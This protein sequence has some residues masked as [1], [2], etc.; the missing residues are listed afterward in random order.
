MRKSKSPP[1][2]ATEVFLAFCS[3]K[4]AVVVMIFLT[5]SLIAATFL[6]S[7]YDTQTAQYWVY[8]A[9]YF[10]GILF[11]FGMEILAVALSRLPWKMRHTPFL[12]AHF[13]IIMLLAGSWVTDRYGLDGTIR[14][15]EG[16]TASVV[17]VNQPTLMITDDT[18][19]KPVPIR[20]T[21]PHAKFKSVSVSEYELKVDQFLSHADPVVSFVPNTD[22]S[23]ETDSTMGA[24]PAV[25]VKLTGGPMRASQDF[26]L[27]AGDPAWTRVQAGPAQLVFETPGDASA[28][29]AKVQLA[30]FGGKQPILKLRMEKDG[31]LKFE[32]RSSG[33][34]VKRGSVVASKVKGTVIEPGWK[35][36]VK[37]SVEEWLS[38]AVSNTTYKPASVQYGNQAPPSAIHVVAG[39]GKD[40]A[41]MWL[42]LGDRAVLQ[43]R[44]KQV[45]IAYLPQRLMLPVSIRLDRF[46]IE[47]YEG[48][49]DPKS[50]ASD[51]VAIGKDGKE[52]PANISMNEPLHH[53]GLTFYQSSY[54][55]ADP[56]PTVS[57]FSV[58][59]DP[60]RQLKYWGSLLIVLGSILLFFV[61]LKKARKQPA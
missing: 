52:T 22:E 3:V 26:W 16:E 15:Q 8:R 1:S 23:S 37:I 43:T 20:W 10:H 32:A 31:S 55:D 45:G 24:A 57:I 25:K 44:G 6:E 12:M 47:R 60:G 21:P 34:E 61:K 35:G 46:N 18:L 30:S 56:R 59:R 11:V 7:I 19:I 29:T 27:W 4:F 33:G 49:N 40:Q 58:N 9:P 14:V 36:A 53:S 13:G 28:D 54:E 41:Q 2:F 42:G 17:E 48:S 5:G 38:S 50:Y 51:V 39:T